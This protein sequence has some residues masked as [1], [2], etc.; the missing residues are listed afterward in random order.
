MPVRPVSGRGQSR[1]SSGSTTT[2]A[3]SRCEERRLRLNPSAP[4]RTTAFLV[5]SAPVPAVVGSAS[6]GTP[7][8]GM[9]RPS[10]T[11]SR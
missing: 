9:G 2:Q 10:P 11:P 3:A 8:P 1:L 5:A 7:G 6:Q 4:A